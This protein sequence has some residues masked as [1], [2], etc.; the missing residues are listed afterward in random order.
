[1][2]CIKSR[3]LARSLAQW[4]VAARQNLSAYPLWPVGGGPACV[5]FT[6]VN[7]LSLWSIS[8]FPILLQG[9]TL[10]YIKPLLSRDI[11]SWSS[12]HFSY[13]LIF[14]VEMLANFAVNTVQSQNQ[15]IQELIRPEPITG[16]VWF[17]TEQLDHVRIPHPPPKKNWTWTKTLPNQE[18]LHP[19]RLLKIT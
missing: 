3:Q 4:S 6:F 2:P 16:F 13:L 12:E 19:L 7:F 9:D 10:I 8:G 14:L 17:S 15:H 11:S 1:M 5:F 18:Y